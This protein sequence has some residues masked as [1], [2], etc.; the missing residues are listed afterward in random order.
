M[1]DI[2]KGEE[3]GK[4]KSIR[5]NGPIFTLIVIFHIKRKVDHTLSI[6]HIST[7]TEGGYTDIMNH[8]LMAVLTEILHK[9]TKK[10][11]ISNPG[12]GKQFVKIGIEN[13]AGRF[14]ASKYTQKQV[15]NEEIKPDE[16]VEYCS[17]FLTE[18]FRQLNV[19]DEEYE[20][21]L[22]ISKKGKCLLSKNKTQKAVKTTE[23]HNRAKNYHLEE[24][25]IIP[26]L[27]DM[28][29][30]TKEGKIVNSMYDK[31][32][33]INKFI[34]IIYDAISKYKFEEINIIDFGCGK[35]YL[36]FV[37]YYFLHEK[38][39]MNVNM[40]GLDLK[41]EVIHKC[42]ETA[43][44]YGYDRLKFEIG[45]INGYKVKTR[46]D[47]VISLHACDTATDYA[48]YN[49]IAWDSKI[50]ISVPCCQHELCGQLTS[51]EM[52]LVERYGIIKERTAALLTDAIRGNL[53]ECCGYKTQLLE[54]VDLAH[55]PKNILIRAVKT[56]IPNSHRLKMLEEVYK[57]TACFHLQPTLLTLLEE[58]NYLPK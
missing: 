53:V 52:P 11:I 26:P 38:L 28:G 48:L 10:I 50:I 24:G 41:E 20:Y 7:K 12:N 33:Q 3:L 18:S 27:V 16:L 30:F 15:F 17:G 43:G 21:S 19:W 49:A 31:F 35:S 58:H 44:K 51:E 46:V 14:Y 22:K 23:T 34:E 4:L 6:I 55:T 13:K 32:K 29:I 40:I 39:G 36:T 47:M 9:D 5:S 8:E 25:E 37:V 54:F 57:T 56:N 45:D 2:I 42:N 1:G